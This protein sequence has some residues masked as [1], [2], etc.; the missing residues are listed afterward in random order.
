MREKTKPD[1]LSS[2]PNK[3]SDSDFTYQ[4][5]HYTMYLN[6]LSVSLIA[7]VQVHA[8]VC[9]MPGT[10]CNDISQVISPDHFT[11]VQY[12]LTVSPTPVTLNTI[13]EERRIR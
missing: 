4:N 13:P 11:D 5:E 7:T 9:K 3:S 1:Q 10:N 6:K 12:L 8:A 2:S